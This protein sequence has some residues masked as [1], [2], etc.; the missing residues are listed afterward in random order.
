MSTSLKVVNGDLSIK[1]GRLEI[2]SGLDKLKQDL[3]L[4]LVEKY[5]DDR[6]HTNW[7]SILDNFIGGV[8]QESTRVRVQTE[9]LRVLQN[10]QQLQIQ[11][12]RDNPARFSPQELLHSVQSV[13]VTITYDKVDALIRFTTVAG[14]SSTVSLNNLGGVF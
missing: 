7:G 12:F 5:G 6:F 10:Y 4:W 14:I 8:I 9:I 2:V 13:Q 1:G 3:T 11:R